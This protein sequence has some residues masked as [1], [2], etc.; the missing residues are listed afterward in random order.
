MLSHLSYV[1]SKINTEKESLLKII[2]SLFT[3]SK[4]IINFI[5]HSRFKELA[6]IRK[7][8]NPT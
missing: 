2:E 7:I 6:K 4:Q 8:G 5:I 1:C 3:S